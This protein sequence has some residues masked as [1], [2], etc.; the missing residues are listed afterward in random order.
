M[1]ILKYKIEVC[2]SAIDRVHGVYETI[3]EFHVPELNFYV[4]SKAEFIED[5]GIMRIPK[6]Y[7]IIENNKKLEDNFIR[8]F[9]TVQE[10]RNI[11]NEMNLFKENS[12][13]ESQ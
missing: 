12:D 10:R 8:L 7:I 6:E 4:N 11:L 9:K 3:T 13:D 2:N 5:L 1:K